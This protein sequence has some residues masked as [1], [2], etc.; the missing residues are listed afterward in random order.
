MQGNH[1]EPKSS[2]RFLLNLA[3]VLNLRTP[4]VLF[5]TT[6]RER[7]MFAF[8]A[9]LHLN[10]C[11]NAYFAISFHMRKNGKMHSS[12]PTGKLDAWKLALQRSLVKSANNVKTI[13]HPDKGLRFL[14]LC[15]KEKKQFS[16]V[17]SQVDY[18]ILKRK[19][20]R[21]IFCKSWGFHWARET[22]LDPSLEVS[23]EKLGA[24]ISNLSRVT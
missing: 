23:A 6:T 18:S 7:S 4:A 20:S 11:K 10:I 5:F 15:K 1:W 12:N 13:H 3:A 14:C 9:N 17:L 24:E 21:I 2:T 8:C 22:V 16:F 19:N